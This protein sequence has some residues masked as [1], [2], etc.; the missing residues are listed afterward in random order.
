MAISY[1][2]PEGTFTHAAA[3]KV[4]VAGP[5]GTAPDLVPLGLVTDVYDQVDRGNSDFG[6]VAIESSVEGYVVPSLD[7]LAAAANVVAVDEVFVEISFDAF[8]RPGSSGEFTSVTSHPHGLAQCQNF[9]VA[10]GLATVAASSNAAACRDVEVGQIALG[11]SICGDLYGL[12]R[13]AAGVQDFSGART[14]FLLIA[15]RDRAQAHLAAVSAGQASP[16]G[17]S[18]TA[19]MRWHT[20]V[21]ITPTVTGP[22]VLARITAEFGSHGVNLSSLITRPVKALEGKYTFIVTVDQA[23]WQPGAKH[24]LEQLLAAGDGLKVLGVFPSR[25]QIDDTVDH[26]RLAPGTARTG[27]S[28]AEANR[29]LLWVGP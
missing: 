9:I 21:A 18:M 10:R 16:L 25:G 4:A 24:V 29:A 22:G 14:R 7:S 11:P 12:T 13:L 17:L 8:A 5:D 3:L 28:V 20:M 23:P 27:V 26:T 2:G 1:L 15:A 19:D 6:L